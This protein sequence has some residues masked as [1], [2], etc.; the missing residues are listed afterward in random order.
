[1]AV[2][3]GVDIQLTR[4]A[5]MPG[6]NS[7]A[8]ATASG[9]DDGPAQPASVLSASGA[10]SRRPSPFGAFGEGGGSHEAGSDGVVF[11]GVI[12]DSKKP[13]AMHPKRQSRSM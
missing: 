11:L 7:P 8:L 12:C 4:A 9:M 10:P 1:M 3:L 6:P 2:A 5:D 13:Q